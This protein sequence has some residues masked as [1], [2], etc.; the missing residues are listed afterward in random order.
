MVFLGN[1]DEYVLKS[2]WPRDSIWTE[3]IPPYWSP[4]REDWFLRHE[5]ELKAGRA[6]PL[7]ASQWRKK[8][9]G[10]SFERRVLKRVEDVSSVF[11]CVNCG[12]AFGRRCTDV[13]SSF[14][15]V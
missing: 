12:E 6:L 15:K 2:W 10:C 8:L 1:G 4:M 14:Y 3:C 9:R 7:S 13:S 5:N 11:A